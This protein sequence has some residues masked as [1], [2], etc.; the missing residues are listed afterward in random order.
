MKIPKGIRVLLYILGFGFGIY[1][2]LVGSGIIGIADTTDL[3]IIK[4]EG[5]EL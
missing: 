1:L 5:G 2:F 4:F 3:N